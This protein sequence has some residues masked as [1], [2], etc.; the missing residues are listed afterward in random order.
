MSSTMPWVRTLFEVAAPSAHSCTAGFA[1]GTSST[2]G[3]VMTATTLVTVQVG[4]GAALMPFLANKDEPPPTAGAVLARASG[5]HCQT[6]SDLSG[7]NLSSVCQRYGQAHR[8]RYSPPCTGDKSLHRFH[9]HG[10]HARPGNAR[11][12]WKNKKDIK[13][14]RAA[15]HLN[16]CMLTRGSVQVSRT[17]QMCVL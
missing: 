1:A 10:L 9:G 6:G 13:T 4:S 16:V 8:A 2:H 15:G 14:A 3:K 7:H 12:W 11:D 5:T 17:E